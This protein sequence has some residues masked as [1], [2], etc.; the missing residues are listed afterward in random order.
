MAMG[1]MMLVGAV[2]IAYDLHDRHRVKLPEF[3]SAAAV[4]LMMTYGTD[5]APN[6][7]FCKVDANG[8]KLLPYR[9]D[10]NVAFACYTMDGTGPELDTSYIQFSQ[11]Y[12][13]VEG[14]IGMRLH[15]RPGFYADTFNGRGGFI[16]YVLMLV[17]KEVQVS[18]FSTLRQARALGVKLIE[19]G[20]Q[21]I[22]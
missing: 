6:E 3:D 10:Y 22:H 11:T 1:V 8:D 7:A 20:S 15:M 19:R 4:S 16:N 5:K 14:Q 2:L 18:Q 21:T 9:D 17:P 13:I 12:D